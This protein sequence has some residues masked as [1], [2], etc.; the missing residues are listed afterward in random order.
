MAQ[1]SYMHLSIIY[2]SAP[3]PNHLE[4]KLTPLATDWVR[5]GSANWIL[6]TDKSAITLYEMTRDVLAP[7]DFCLIHRMDMTSPPNGFLP[8]WIW[9]WLNKFRDPNTGYVGPTPDEFAMLKAIESARAWNL[10]PPPTPL[11]ISPP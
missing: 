2:A 6:W 3:A 9:Q 7:D 11:K 10:P 4:A 8:M 1:H 5:Y